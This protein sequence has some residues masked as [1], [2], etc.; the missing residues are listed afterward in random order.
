MLTYFKKKWLFSSYI[1][2]LGI[3]VALLSIFQGI[4]LQLI[5]D[6]AVGNLAFGFAKM[7]ILV[8][9][10][11]IFNFI[12]CFL[13]KKNL[14]RI[15]TGAITDIKNRLI[16]SFL[17]EKNVGNFELT[18][19]IATMEKDTTHVFENYYINFFVL[20]NQIILF[21]LATIYL[22]FTNAFLT[23]LVLFSG[24]VSILL[25]QFFVPRAQEV[26]EQY[27]NSNKDY[28]HNIKELINGLTIIKVFDLEK[29]RGKR[30]QDSNFELEKN[31]RQQLNYQSFIECLSSS[32][33][34]LVLACNVVFAGYLS[35][36]GHFTIGTVLAVMQIMNF[37]MH[38]L[39][40]IPSIMIEMKSVKPAIDNI[41]KYMINPKE[42]KLE[43]QELSSFNCLKFEHVFFK[44]AEAR[45]YILEDININFEKNKKYVIVG[46]SGSGKTTLLKLILGLHKNFQG[47]IVVNQ[48]KK[49][50]DI[51][52]DKWRRVLTIVEQEIFVFN[53]TINYNVCFEKENEEINIWDLFS[54][55]GLREFLKTKDDNIE[56]I[57]GENGENIS[58][59]EKKR[60][61]VAR[62][63]YKQ[64]EIILADEPTSGLDA[65]NAK[66]IDD[67][68]IGSKQMVINITHNLDREVL[69]RYDEIICMKNGK[70]VG[71][72]N[73]DTLFSQ[74]LYFQKLCE[75]FNQNLHME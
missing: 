32:M 49:L 5:V 64:S 18:E 62:A 38:P 55:V 12:F 67:I 56:Y 50:K 75:D 41:K 36:K 25:P 30:V 14:Y 19:K 65:S 42:K 2:L 39:M 57:L 21:L 47:D 13:Y 58:G 40:Q 70:V 51:P 71:I 6:T 28:L 7:I 3:I 48:E 59:G 11:V 16:E 54:L 61:A 37:I 1:I 72:G 8:I 35:Y 27:L 69:Q 10:Y 44:L 45:E 26:N 66:L 20:I 33:S 22:F 15:S 4:M 52:V 43:N 31:H 46:C 34:F 68:L 73:Y 9:T 17:D 24:I 29:E 53:D 60:L 63:L 74:N 23:F